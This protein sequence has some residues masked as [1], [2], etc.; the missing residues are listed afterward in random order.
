LHYPSSQRQAP[1]VAAPVTLV[2]LRTLDEALV[3]LEAIL[4]Q[5][6]GLGYSRRGVFGVRLALEEALVNA[7]KHG[8]R[9]DPSKV[10][11]LRLRVSA[12]EVFAE[13][14]DEGP[15]FDHR[16]VVDPRLAENRE[17]PCGRGLMLM[18][19]YL[20]S[21]EYNERG[22]RVVLRLGRQAVPV[23]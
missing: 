11:R 10:V 4:A 5:M 12:D 22:N 21:V 16:L 19:H 20:T 18:R 6:A 13:V 1:A 8:H 3:E 23:G 17:R 9:H 7:I 2:N 15:G 14:E